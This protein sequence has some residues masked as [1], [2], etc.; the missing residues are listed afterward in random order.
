M[1]PLGGEEA[2]GVEFV[3][4]VE[5]PG[6]AVQL[7]GSALGGVAGD[8]GERVRVLSRVIIGDELELADGVDRW[9]DLRIIRKVAARESDAVVV[10]LVGEGSAAADMF[11][12]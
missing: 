10:H 1:R 11:L 3:V 2:A 4:I 8:A 12:P 5:L 9:G 6:A 7:I